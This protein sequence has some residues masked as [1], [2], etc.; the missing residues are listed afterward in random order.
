MMADEDLR[1]VNLRLPGALIDRLDA[2]AE[3]L[4]RRSPGIL[5]SR[6]DVIRSLLLQG[7][8]QAEAEAGEGE[9]CK[10]PKR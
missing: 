8:D 7:L 5:Y 6:A 3:R 2:Q 10:P 4:R 1:Q 9:G